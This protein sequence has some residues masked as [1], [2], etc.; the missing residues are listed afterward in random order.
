[1]T[2]L[3]VIDEL[4]EM[5][6]RASGRDRGLEGGLTRATDDLMGRPDSLDQRFPIELRL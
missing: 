4:F 5:K 6:Q 2:P 3:T 1:V